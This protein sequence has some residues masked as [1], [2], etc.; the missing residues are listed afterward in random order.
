MPTLNAV[1]KLKNFEFVYT[2]YTCKPF[3]HICVD[4]LSSN[5][6]TKE[7][8]NYSRLK[9]EIYLNGKPIRTKRLV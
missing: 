1:E 4:H 5:T 6:A 2:I 9:K 8:A 7:A 3:M